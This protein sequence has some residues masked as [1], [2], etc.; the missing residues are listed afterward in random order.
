MKKKLLVT[1]L[2]MSMLATA[3]VT[4][5]ACFAVKDKRTS[6]LAQTDASIEQ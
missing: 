4:A 2:A 5:T 6:D 3:G 1:I